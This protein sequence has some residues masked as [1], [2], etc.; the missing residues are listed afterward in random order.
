MAPK[1]KPTATAAAPAP[2]APAADSNSYAPP[3]SVSEKV[4]QVY[5]HE[6]TPVFVLAWRADSWSVEGDSVIPSLLHLPLVPGV[7]GVSLGRD[8]Q[9]KVKDWMADR[10]ERGDTIIPYEIDGAGTSY[11]RRY[12][13]RGGYAHLLRFQTLHPNAIEAET[14]VL[15][16]REWRAGLVT[17]GIVPP[18]SRGVIDSMLAMYQQQASRVADQAL[19]LPSAKVELAELERKVRVLESYIDERWSAPA[20]E[21][22][23]V[24]AV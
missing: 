2:V 17:R 18:P 5:R 13:V 9:I 7:N 3:F 19:T 4:E 16:W 20:E 12:P 6:I 1:L 14:D 22:P 8:N 24:P 10:R 21:A 11:M 23:S 15:G